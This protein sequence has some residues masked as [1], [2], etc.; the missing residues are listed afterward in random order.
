[1]KRSKEE[2]IFKMLKD[3]EPAEGLALLSGLFPGKIVFTTSFGLEDQVITDMIFT[4]RL[5][6][7]IVTLDTGRLFRETYKVFSKTIEKY[8]RNIRCYYPETAAVEKLLSEKGPFSFYESVENRKECCHIRKVEPLDR[9]LQGYGVLDHRN[10][11]HT[12]NKP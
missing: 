4:A 6:I 9:A 8:G 2:E 7:E 12:V 11:V 3:K 10:T 1:M 5:D